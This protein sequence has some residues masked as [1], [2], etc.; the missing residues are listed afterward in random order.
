MTRSRASAGRSGSTS[1]G[2]VTVLL[3]TDG[4]LG[5]VDDAALDEGAKVSDCG[6][7]DVDR[8]P[9]QSGA[10]VP[11]GVEPGV[12]AGKD[13]P[14]LLVSGALDGDRTGEVSGADDREIFVEAVR[15]SLDEQVNRWL[16]TFRS[17][18]YG[19]KIYEYV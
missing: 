11:V 2:A 19:W 8:S 9:F 1:D 14:L 4:Y 7:F 13:G 3:G 18:R 12:E 6:V 16:T 17:W 15:R 5:L 10:L